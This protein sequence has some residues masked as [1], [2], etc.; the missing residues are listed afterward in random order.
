MQA[1]FRES[2]VF[3]STLVNPSEPEARLIL[4]IT[5]SQSCF[6]SRLN[7]NVY[8]NAHRRNLTYFKVLKKRIL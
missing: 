3:N 8:E 5:E 6:T 1:V 2:S 4:L 7:R